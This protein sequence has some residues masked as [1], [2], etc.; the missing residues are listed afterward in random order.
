MPF[1]S[2][3]EFADEIRPTIYKPLCQ[4]IEKARNEVTSQNCLWIY[5][6]FSIKLS[7]SLLP[8]CKIKS[9]NLDVKM[10]GGNGRCLMYL[11]EEKMIPSIVFMVSA[12]KM[13]ERNKSQAISDEDTT[14]K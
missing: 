8:F 11:G 6:D 13:A 5:L 7:V 9:T 4:V 14:K 3:I 10:V 1:Y 12:H 2:Y